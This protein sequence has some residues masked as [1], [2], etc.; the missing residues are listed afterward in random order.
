MGD[1][2]IVFRLRAQ[3]R[4]L[5]DR[6]VVDGD[7]LEERSKSRG[8]PGKTTTCVA[9]SSARRPGVVRIATSQRQIIRTDSITGDDVSRA[10]IRLEAGEAWRNIEERDA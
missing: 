4:S 2:R 5:Q 8:P 9:D 1:I 7:I 6:I 10:C 3:L